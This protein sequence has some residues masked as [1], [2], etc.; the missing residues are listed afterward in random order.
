[1]SIDAI[2]E[3]KPS[4]VQ[5][6]REPSKFPARI[7]VVDD[8]EAVAR[9]TALVLRDIGHV[10]IVAHSGEEAVA[11]FA[12]EAPIDLLVSDVVLPGSLCGYELAE[13]LRVQ[14]PTLPVIFFTGYPMD[15]IEKESGFS[16]DFPHLLKPAM[17]SDIR[18]VVM[19]VLEV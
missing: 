4:D 5:S 14:Q 8:C 11:A 16:D 12:S 1:M 7:L 9:V 17:I 18:D 10:A 15:M 2:N 13:A 19:A 3:N 6:R